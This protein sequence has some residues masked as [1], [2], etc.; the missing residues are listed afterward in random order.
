M[1]GEQRTTSFVKP[2]GTYP[3]TYRRSNISSSLSVGHTWWKTSPIISKSQLVFDNFTTT[4]YLVKDPS[5]RHHHRCPATTAEYP[6]NHRQWHWKRKYNCC[7]ASHME[8]WSKSTIASVSLTSRRHC[9]CPTHRCLLS[10]V[11]LSISLPFSQLL[12]LRLHFGGGGDTPSIC[13]FCP[14]PKPLLRIH[15]LSI[16]LPLPQPDSQK[17]CPIKT[18]SEQSKSRLIPY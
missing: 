13:R 10:F 17:L 6:S 18:C 11:L 9:H 1:T 7:H 14:F 16:Y 12:F 4:A 3:L 5:I 2:E 15:S 8:N